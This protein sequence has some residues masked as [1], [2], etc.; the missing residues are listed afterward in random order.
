[1]KRHLI[2]IS[3]VVPAFVVLA[4]GWVISQRIQ[5]DARDLRLCRTAQQ[6][7]A[8]YAGFRDYA[9]RVPDDVILAK[10]MDQEVFLPRAR[11][12][13]VLVDALRREA[14]DQF[15]TASEFAKPD[16]ALR[17]AQLAKQMQG[18]ESELQSHYRCPVP[19]VPEKYFDQYIV[20]KPRVSF[21]APAWDSVFVAALKRNT[22]VAAQYHEYVRHDTKVL[23]RSR[24]GLAKALVI[25][26]YLGNRCVK[27]K[28]VASLKCDT[29]M[30][31][32]E[33][34]VNEL[35]AVVS[36]NE[37]KFKEKWGKWQISTPIE[38]ARRT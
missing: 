28:G 30:R 29:P 13:R 14:S 27:K 5:R 12:Q 31:R 32:L 18:W 33:Q 15:P 37:A 23:C 26:E 19:L 20:T 24:D 22:A 9:G 34:Q 16:A 2:L 10:L 7:A 8:E 17:S 38:C 6:L 4:G 3:I 21:E 35:T 11:K 1:M 36:L 25:R